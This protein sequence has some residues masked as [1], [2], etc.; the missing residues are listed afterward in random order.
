M[1]DLFFLSSL[2]QIF[3]WARSG[4]L[5]FFSTGCGCC[6]DEVLQSVGCRYDI[7]RFGC[8]Q[9]VDPK[10][11][12]LLII[13]GAVSYKAAPELKKIYEL[14]CPPKHV[15]AIGACACRG[16]PFAPQFSYSVVPEINR[17]VPVDVFV[18][19]CPP[20]PEAIMNGL[21]TLQE[22]RS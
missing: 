4:S 22:K 12:D 3:K 13:S 14:M 5:W 18:P 15:M 2:E 9:Q 6:G 11:A 16:G 10:Q 21:I 1:K 8:L 20:R 7:E 19:G 17:I